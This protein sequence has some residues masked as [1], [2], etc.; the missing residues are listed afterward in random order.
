MGASPCFNLPFLAEEIQSFASLP[1]QGSP[2]SVALV[3]PSPAFKAREQ[4]CLTP[5]LVASVVLKPSPSA[6]HLSVR[7]N[8]VLSTV[9]LVMT[10]GSS[11]LLPAQNVLNLFQLFSS[12]FEERFSTMFFSTSSLF[13]VDEAILV[14]K[15][16]FF[17]SIN[18]I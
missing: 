14:L 1:S 4:W 10:V 15:F 6:Q 12:C 13:L 2:T 5:L 9:L 7:R 8:F 11:S 18:C 17:T 3:H 16:F